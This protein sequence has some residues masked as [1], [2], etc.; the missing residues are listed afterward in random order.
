MLVL[1][2]PTSAMDG[3]TEQKI[4]T[5]LLNL[6]YNPTIVI[7]THRTNHLSEVDKIGILV[8]EN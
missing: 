1:D 2:E 3:Q 4:I 5:N 6:D 7:S 8:M